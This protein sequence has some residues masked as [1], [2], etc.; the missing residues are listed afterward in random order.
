[1]AGRLG[2]ARLALADPDVPV[3]PI[4]Q[5]GVQESIDLYQQAGAAVPA[6]PALDR[7]SASRSTCRRFAAS[8]RS[9][10]TLFR[11]TDVIMSDMRDL[12]A[13]LRG[14]PAPTGSFYR[15]RR[16]GAGAADRGPQ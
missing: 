12:V 16:V 5:W 14:V 13:E 3:I 11:M 15:W 4:A 9:A 8:S 7:R 10:T 2:T 1:M 6:A